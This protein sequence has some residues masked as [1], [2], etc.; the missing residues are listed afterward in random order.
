MIRGLLLA[1]AWPFS[2]LAGDGICSLTFDSGV[3]LNGVALAQS[4]ETQTRGLS[5]SDE[6]GGGMLF[7]WREAEPRV[8]WMRDTRV[9]L[10]LAW[11][12]DGGRLFGIEDLKPNTDV[13]HLSL[14]P[15]VAALELPRG[16]FA[17]RRLAEG[18]R[19]V[20]RSCE[21]LPVIPSSR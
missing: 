2:V 4:K 21:T 5:D 16:D 15:A 11:I 6:A 19:L 12:D 1:A 17:R 7:A 8:V 20:S 10:T 9:P 18:D 3:V 14:M 13:F